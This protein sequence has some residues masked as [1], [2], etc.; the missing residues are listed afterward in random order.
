MR[1]GIEML[2][3][4]KLTKAQA[5]AV[6]A[7]LK[8]RSNMKLQ[9]NISCLIGEKAKHER[10]RS[11]FALEKFKP[12]NELDLVTFTVALT[13]G[14]EVVKTLSDK[15]NDRNNKNIDG[16]N[17]RDWDKGYNI[18]FRDGVRFMVQEQDLETIH[19]NNLG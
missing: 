3:K 12:A 9:D 16:G 14:Y 17:I 10:D 6:E 5:D 4:V 1:G 19:F 11:G 13:V 8:V 15:A 18:G 7:L 2:E